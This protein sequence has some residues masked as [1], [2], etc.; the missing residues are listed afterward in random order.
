M[1]AML[2][3]ATRTFLEAQLSG[4]RRRALDLVAELQATGR[5]SPSAVRAEVIR[6]AQVEIG[7]LWE[8]SAI[9]IAQEHMATAIAHLALASLFEREAPQPSNGR[10]V[11]VACVDGELHEFPAR[12]VADELEAAGFEV[13]FLGAS[14]PAAALVDLAMRERPDLVLLSATLAMHADT[15]RTTVAALRAR[16]PG[17]PVAVGG[18]VC[19]WVETLGTELGVPIAGCDAATLVAQAETLLDVSS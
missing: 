5:L 1:T 11:V 6:P 10:R 18:Q 2:N 14:V 16:L 17:L 8:T 13:R 7:R 12:L 9:S 3:P 19:A 4:D 15:V